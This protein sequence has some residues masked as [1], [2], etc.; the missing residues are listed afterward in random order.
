MSS[1]LWPYH[2]LYYKY[3]R[4]QRFWLDP[5]AEYGALACLLIVEALNIYTLLC[6]A[7]LIAGRRLLPPFSSAQSLWVLVVLAILQYFALIRRHKYKRI[8]QRFIHESPRQR[9]IGGIAVTIYTVGS[10]ILFFWLASLL[11]YTPNQTMEPTAP[12]RNE[13]THSLPLFRPSACPSM[14]HRFP[15]A[16]FSVLATTPWISSRCPATLVRFMS[17]HSRTPAVKLFNACRGL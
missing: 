17:W 14:S 1:L 12:S 8:A 15:R 11:S 3:Y 9:L 7:D 16:P 2:Y 4:L 6:T 5:A 13:L 10:F